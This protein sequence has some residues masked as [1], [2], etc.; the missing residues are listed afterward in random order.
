M[1]TARP[2]A[3]PHTSLRRPSVDQA[4]VAVKRFQFRVCAQLVVFTWRQS[5]VDSFAERGEC[6]VSSALE[7][8]GLGQGTSGFS[9]VEVIAPE[10][11]A[12]RIVGFVEELFLLRIAVTAI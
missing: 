6:V 9:S 3:M 4:R 7:R 11:A 1:A 10:H 2:Q 5:M 8:I 12:A